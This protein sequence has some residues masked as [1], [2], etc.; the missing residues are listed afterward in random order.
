M[1]RTGQTVYMEVVAKEITVVEVSGETSMEI[2]L[3]KSSFW[4]GRFNNKYNLLPLF[5]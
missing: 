4:G 5:S 1:T 2:I 3:K